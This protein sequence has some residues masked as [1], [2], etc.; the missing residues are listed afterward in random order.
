MA[1]DNKV[2]L[3]MKPIVCFLYLSGLLFLFQIN[4]KDVQGTG[5]DGRI[6][7][8]DMLR[9]IETV[10]SRK[11]SSAPV[12]QAAAVS[13]QATA[14]QPAPS[15]FKTT[16]VGKKSAGVD[17]TEPIKGFKKAMVKSMNVALVN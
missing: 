2:W 6:L 4:L 17:R 9:H 14:K 12:Q 11:K 16:T 10:N 13:P 3:S 8:E 7:K 5:R 15:A 1:I